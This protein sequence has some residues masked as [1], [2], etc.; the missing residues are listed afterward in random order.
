MS[1]DF[2]E[3]ILDKGVSFGVEINYVIGEK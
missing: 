2:K 1:K 3:N